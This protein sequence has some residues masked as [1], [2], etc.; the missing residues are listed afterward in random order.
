LA[1]TPFLPSTAVT[2]TAIIWRTIPSV[3]QPFVRKEGIFPIYEPPM[4]LPFSAYDFFGYLASGFLI[5]CAVEFA[6]DGEW[7]LFKKLSVPLY[8]FWAVAAYIVGHIVANISSYFIEHKFVRGVLKSPEVRLFSDK[9]SKWR[10]LFPIFFQPFPKAT[11]DRILH[12]AEKEGFIKADR[13]MF[14]HCHAVVKKFKTTKERLNNFL[15]VYGFCRN[16]CMASL[17]TIPILAAGI[18]YSTWPN[19]MY[20]KYWTTADIHRVWWAVAALLVAI[21]MLYRYLKFFKHYTQ[22]VLTTYGELKEPEPK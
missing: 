14:L 18:I 4:K 9:L 20:R 15:N 17:M 21:G 12:R 10:Y 8:V 16:I 7:L 22:E 1:G 13:A 6:F 11:Q 19:T 2:G 5:L 3:I